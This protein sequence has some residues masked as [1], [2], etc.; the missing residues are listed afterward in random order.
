MSLET[1]LWHAE[2]P[3]SNLLAQPSNTMSNSDIEIDPEI[4][5]PEDEPQVEQIKKL[6]ATQHDTVSRMM[7]SQLRQSFLK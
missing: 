3:S 6:I 7:F 2:H 5:I 4:V 1:Q